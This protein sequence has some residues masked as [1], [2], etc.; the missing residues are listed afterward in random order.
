MIDAALIERGDARAV[1]DVHPVGAGRE[2]DLA[3]AGGQRSFAAVRSAE[4]LELGDGREAGGRLSAA[5]RDVR[6]SWPIACRSSLV[7]AR[8]SHPGDR[9]SRAGAR[10]FSAQPISAA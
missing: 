1:M 5:G 6:E 2:D 7:R 10:A 3:V 8:S 9:R 4:L